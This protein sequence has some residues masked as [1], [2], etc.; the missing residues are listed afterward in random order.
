MFLTNEVAEGLL[1]TTRRKFRHPVILAAGSRSH[2]G[3]L[4]DRSVNACHSEATNYQ[5]P[6]EQCRTTID[7]DEGEQSVICV[8]REIQTGCVS[9][10]QQDLPAGHD[11]RSKAQHGDELEVA[12]QRQLV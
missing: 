11:S 10:R 6:E 7:E 3:H 2:R 4:G 9:L 12:L 5:A 1:H 8:S